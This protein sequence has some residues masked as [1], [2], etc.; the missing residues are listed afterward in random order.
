MKAPDASRLK[1]AQIP[2]GKLRHVWSRMRFRKSLMAI[3]MVGASLLSVSCFEDLDDNYREAS[4]TEINDFIWRGL[5][6]FYLYKGSVPNLQDNAFDSQGDKKAYLASFDTPEDCFEALTDP[7]DPFSLLVEDYLTLENSLAGISLS[8]GMEYGLV[9][10]PQDNSLIFGYVRYVLPGSDAAT[11]NLQ[12]GMIFNRVDGT[13]L[14]ATNYNDLLSPDTYTLGWATYDGTEITPLS[15]TT[16]LTKTQLSENPVHRTVVFSENG[17]TIGYLMYNGFTNEYD[18]DLNAAFGNFAA[19]GV[20]DLILDLRYNGGGSVRTATSL[21]GMIT[22]QFQGEIFFTEQW[23]ADRQAQYAEPG[24]FVSTLANGAGL[25]SL[26]LTRVY[27]LTSGR[28]AS[29]S[30]LVINGLKPYIDVV[31]IGLPT[32]GK[33]QASFLLYDAPAP[34][35]SRNQANTG[36]RYAMLPL[37][38]KTLNAAGVTDYANGL[39]PDIEL[40]EDFSN[41]GQLGQTDEPLLARAISEILGQPLPFDQPPSRAGQ[42][43]ELQVQRDALDGVM[44]R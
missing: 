32:R 18:N 28:T 9:Y 34:S 6:Y 33:Y 36:H 41:L 29:A 24:Y 3:A 13:Q 25:N 20:T 23:N 37:V 11:Q 26:G 42:W 16:T 35:F 17:H 40:S 44:Y 7:S 14:T 43:H 38:F 21:A 2:K 22:G 27:V 8:N 10:Y 31:Q 4:T 5:N 39:T 30:E 12:R 19:Q 1:I 15:D